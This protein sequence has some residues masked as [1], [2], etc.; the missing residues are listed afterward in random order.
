M[1]IKILILNESILNM[2]IHLSWGDLDN[3]KFF[4][5]EIIQGIYSRRNINDVGNHYKVLCGV[6]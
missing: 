3:S 1:Q 4:I 2:I 5:E 6:L